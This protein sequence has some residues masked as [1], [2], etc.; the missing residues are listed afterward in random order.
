MENQGNEAH[1]R[2]GGGGCDAGLGWAVLR[3]LAEVHAD[4]AHSDP[5]ERLLTSCRLVYSMVLL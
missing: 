5:I 4:V 3:V 2:G 1:D